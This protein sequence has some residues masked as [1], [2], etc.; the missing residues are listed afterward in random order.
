MTRYAKSNQTI[1]DLMALVEKSGDPEYGASVYG[2]LNGSGGAAAD[3]VRE[4]LS[5][6]NVDFEN[7]EEFGTEDGYNHLSGLEDLGGYEMIGSGPSA[8]PVLWCAG[9]GDWEL[10]LVFILYIGQKGELRAYIP[11]NGNAYNH[12]EKCAYGSE[13]NSWDDDYERMDPDDPRYVFDVAA[14]RADIIGRIVVKADG[15]LPSL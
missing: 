11:E 1:D 14:M 15:N 4:D 7:V 5:K 3:K 2:I 10:P 12:E 6:V 8:F 9:G 13:P